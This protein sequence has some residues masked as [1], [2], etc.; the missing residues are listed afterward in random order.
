MRCVAECPGGAIPRDRSV[1]IEVEGHKIEWADI[2]LGKC[3]LTH[4]GLNRKNGQFLAKRYPGLY[5]PIAEQ[6]VT[7]REAWDVGWSM[8]PSFPYFSAISR[9][10]VPAL[11][12]AR[13]C[14]IGCMKHLEQKGRVRNTFRSKPI[15]SESAPWS[16]PE[17]P[18]SASHRGFVY[19]PDADSQE[20]ADAE[21]GTTWY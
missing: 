2:D 21:P 14:I 1:S 3:K 20:P 11:C 19:D 15:F 5:I 17:K 8:F 16:L 12:G 13:G 4:F 18:E 6:E 7:W 9:Y 10:G